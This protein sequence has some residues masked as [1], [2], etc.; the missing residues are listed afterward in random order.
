MPRA[1]GRKAAAKKTAQRGPGKR[2]ARKVART[3]GATGMSGAISSLRACHAG[4]V[5]QRKELDGQLDVLARALEA[6]TGTPGRRA[7][8]KPGRKPGPKPGTGGTFRPGSLKA[9]IAKAL[10]GGGVLAVKDI[11]TGVLKSGYKTKNKTLAKSVG[12]ALTEMRGATKVGR[13]R[14]HMR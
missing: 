9:Y 5:A 10:K 4:L 14:F 1:K 7:G 12:I 3:V 13:G 2:R 6:V 8:R 11:T